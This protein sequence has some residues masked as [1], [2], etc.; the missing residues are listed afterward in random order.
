M[1]PPLSETLHEWM[2]VTMRYSMRGFMLYA[3]EHNYSLPQLNMLFRLQ[4]KGVCGVSELAEELGVTAAAASQLLERLVQQGLV[5]RA[6]NPLDRRNRRMML[7]EA[8]RLVVQQSV[9]ARQSWLNRLPEVLSEAEQEQI[10]AALRLLIE[11]ATAFNERD[12]SL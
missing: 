7:T 12:E 4:H 6:E 5:E 9:A 2:C 3:K 1:S 11:R 8:G 10:N